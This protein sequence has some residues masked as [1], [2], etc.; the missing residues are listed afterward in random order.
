MSLN[1]PLNEVSER[2]VRR[3]FA[4]EYKLRIL[5][6][7]EVCTEPGQLGE[8]LRREG[9][10]WTTAQGTDDVPASNVARHAALVTFCRS[11]TGCGLRLAA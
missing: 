5:G 1:T 9:H 2:P 11:G 6:E 3:R 8:L 4:A 10:Y 7:A